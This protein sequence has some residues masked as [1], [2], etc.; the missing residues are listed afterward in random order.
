MVRIPENARRLRQ[1]K[2]GTRPYALPAYPLGPLGMLIHNSFMKRTAWLAEFSKLIGPAK[3][4]REPTQRIRFN[5]VRGKR[6]D[7]GNGT[8]QTLE[9][10]VF[11][12]LRTIRDGSRCHPL[13][14][15]GTKRA[16][17]WQQ[18]WV[19]FFPAAHNGEKIGPNQNIC[20]SGSGLCGGK[21]LARRYADAG[22][23]P[24]PLN[25][26]P[27]VLRLLYQMKNPLLGGA[28]GRWFSFR[29]LHEFPQK[30]ADALAL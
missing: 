26:K 11:E 8:L 19:G 10:A 12:A 28:G 30:G 27:R 2:P 24:K 14:A 4:A 9:P 23:K 25:P 21:I 6:S 15:L 22:A 13:L 7:F 3:F 17:D 5:W 1:S 16:V 18:L 29:H 20:L